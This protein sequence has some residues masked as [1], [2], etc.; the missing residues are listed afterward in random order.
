MIDLQRAKVEFKKYI[1]NYKNQDA[2]GFQLKVVHTYNVV[3]NAIMI[4]KK[5]GLSQEDVDLAALI[6]ILHDIGRFDELKN[7]QRFD[8]VGNDHAMFASKI[9]FDEGYLSKFIS[10][11]KYNNIIKKAIENHNKKT[12]EDGLSERELL[13]A[14]IIRDA[15]KLDNYRVKVDETIENIFPGLVKELS[16]LEDSLISD[17]VY[18]NIMNEECV[19]IRDRVYPLDYWIC[20]LAFTFDINFKETLLII[21]EKDYINL[22]VDKYSFTTSKNKMDSIRNKINNYIDRRLNE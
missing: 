4:A 14:K 3:N 15:D 9:L 11:D 21:K 13:H 8:S 5:L 12:I 16:D 7:L 19:D 18:N 1:D 10:T 17:K 20:I 6:A 2:A 22:L